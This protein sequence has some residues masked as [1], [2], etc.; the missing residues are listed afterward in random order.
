MEIRDNLSVAEI[1]EMKEQLL[2]QLPE[3]SVALTVD[4]PEELSVDLYTA[5]FVVMLIY[6]AL[7]QTNFSITV[8][9]TSH[10][11]F[12]FHEPVF[13]RLLNQLHHG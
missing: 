2:D 8:T 1:T 7:S 5:Q 12:R 4:M 3:Q 6:E 9:E 11:Y 13:T 10:H